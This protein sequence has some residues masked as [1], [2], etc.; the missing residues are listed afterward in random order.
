[1]QWAFMTANYVGQA[2]GYANN[3]DW[4]ANHRATVEAFHGPQFAERFAE[5]IDGIKAAGFD[6]IELWIAHLEPLRATP[7]MIATANQ[8]LR[9]HGVK[10]ISYTA[11]FGQPGVTREDATRIFQTASA[12]GAPVLAQGFH[13]ANGPLVRE[14]GERYDIRMGLENHPQKT[15]QE[16]IDTVAPFAPW[17]GSA[18]DTGWFA[19][20][21]F[22]AVRAV[23]ELRDYLVHVHLKD[24]TAVGGHE[25][26]ALGDGVVD[27]PGVL[28]A[29]KEIGYAGAV[30]IEHEPYD[31]DPT[32]ECRVSRERAAAWWAEL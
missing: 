12:I 21:G 14:L 30:T 10:L 25:T 23:H 6:A 20:Q 26:C 32:E 22:D 18:I 1:M 16:V 11:G 3:T 2:L 5:M 9:D 24:I 13:P 15:A 31:H 19:T 7:E 28:R 8:I 17:V 27:I 4:M 29:L